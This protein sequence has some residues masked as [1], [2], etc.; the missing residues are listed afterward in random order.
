[1]RAPFPA[2][3][4]F[5]T[6]KPERLIER[7][8]AIATDP[9]DLVVDSFLGSGTTAAVAHKMTRRW[10]G[11][12]VRAETIER[13]ALPRLK[14]V[15]DGTDRGGISRAVDWPGGGGFRLARTISTSHRVD[16][17][18]QADMETEVAA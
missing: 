1:M 16:G 10:I 18:D 3:P 13:F 17:Q 2:E 11:I 9:E 6:P 15:I 8:I 12:E 14:A 7:I 4:P 5:L